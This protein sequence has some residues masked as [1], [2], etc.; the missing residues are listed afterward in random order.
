[1]S[2]FRPAPAM[3]RRRFFGNTGLLLGAAVA[4]PPLLTAC[5]AKAGGGE[6]SMQLGYLLGEGQLGEAVALAKGWYSE[7]G[8]TFS[9]KQGGPSNDGLSLVVGGQSPIGEVSSSPSLMLA[10]SQG[11]PLRSFGV[12]VQRHPYAYL[13]R[14]EKPVHEPKDLVGK[15][16]GTQA[17]GKILLSA[18]LAANDID[19]ASVEVSVVGSDVTPLTTGQVDVW[20]GWLSNVAVIRPLAGKYVAMRLWDSGIKLYAYPYYATEATLASNR[21]KLTQFLSATARGWQYA[22]ENLD[23]AAGMLVK[24]QPTL[25]PQ[26]IKEQGKVLLEYMFTEDT[27]KNGWGTMDR[28]VWQTQID[29]YAKLG[30]FAGAPPKVDDLVDFSILDATAGSRPKIG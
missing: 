17:T 5:G 16:V 4:A 25:N 8:I 28:S 14:P 15:K 2:S 9:L 24:N 10:R 7:A 6:M 19:P 1:M 13:S 27:A 3:S 12:G 23:E 18:M 20:T 30:Q 21:D 11:M 26:D 22:R 29:T